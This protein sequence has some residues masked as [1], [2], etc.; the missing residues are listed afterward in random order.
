[1]RGFNPIG[2]A[3]CVYEGFRVIFLAAAFLVLRPEGSEAFPW[4]AAITP[5]ALFFLM[6]LFWRLDRSRY[7]AYGPLYLAGK[8]L[9]II[10]ALL[11]QF[12][13]KGDTIQD[14]PVGG[15][16][17]FIVP[18]I[19]VFFLLGDMLSAWQAARLMKT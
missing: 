15:P 18:G 6:A 9:S 2:T 16:A 19:T 3:L 1:M 12:L 7:E 4:L 17:F 11:W 10:M 13:M 8:R 14:K 5:G